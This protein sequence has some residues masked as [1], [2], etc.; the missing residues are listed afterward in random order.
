PGPTCRL[1]R[2]RVES[3]RSG[4][5]D[6]LVVAGKTFCQSP[7]LFSL[8]SVGATGCLRFT[9]SRELGGVCV[10]ITLLIMRW[11]LLGR[12]A[13]WGSRLVVVVGRGVGRRLAIMLFF[14]PR[15]SLRSRSVGCR[16]PGRRRLRLGPH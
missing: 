2:P 11:G 5:V 9:G 10:M 4:D 8:G 7:D 6:C 16:K 13:T 1:H 12:L 14:L 3:R 15:R